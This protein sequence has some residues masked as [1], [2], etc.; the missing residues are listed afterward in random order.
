M[1]NASD[2]NAITDTLEAAVDAFNEEGDGIPTDEETI[3]T[4]DDWKAQLTKGCTLRR[5]VEQV[6]GD[7]YYTAT[8]ELCFGAIERSIEAYALA[9]GGDELRDFHDH[10]YCYD[11]AA[12]LALL[13]RSTTD[14]LRGLYT[15]NRTDSYYGGKQPT[16]AQAEAMKTLAREIHCHAKNQIREGGVCICYPQPSERSCLVSHIVPDDEGLKPRFGS[17]HRIT[18]RRTPDITAHLTRNGGRRYSRFRRSWSS[19]TIPTPPRMNTHRSVAA[20]VSVR[21]PN[22]PILATRIPTVDRGR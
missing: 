19:R 22:T 6:D 13:S 18:E 16:E 21:S 20:P 10:T 11:R 12:E 8:I 1:S 2:P 5:V 9:E 15:E 7:G 14:E 4:G 17:V 3:D